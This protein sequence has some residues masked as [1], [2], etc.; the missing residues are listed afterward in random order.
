[1]I[2]PLGAR[3]PGVTVSGLSTLYYLRPQL[4]LHLPP[5]RFGIN[6]SDTPVMRRSPSSLTRLPSSAHQATPMVSAML[7]NLLDMFAF[8]FMLPPLVLVTYFSYY[9]VISG[10]RLSLVSLVTNTILSFL[11]IIRIIYGRSLYVSSLTLFLPCRIFSLMYTPSL[12]FLFKDSKAIMVANST[13]LVLAHSLRPT[14]FFFACRA[15]T[16]PLRISK[17]NALSAPPTMLFVSC[18]FTQVYHLP[19]GPPPSAWR[20]TPSTFSPP[21]PS[22]SPLP[23]LHCLVYNH[24]MST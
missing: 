10:P 22:L 18:Y 11:M 17:P 13:I 8:R 1:M 12:V 9:T 19:I 3:S 20:H 4:Y 16:P 15:H 6:G 21:K 5:R 7:A 2:F 23:T 14:E 24:P